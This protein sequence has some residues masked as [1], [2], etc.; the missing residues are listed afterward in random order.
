MVKYSRRLDFK[1]AGEKRGVCVPVLSSSPLGG[2]VTAPLP[3]R[4]CSDRL[5]SGLYFRLRAFGPSP[6]IFEGASPAGSQ[7]WPLY[8]QV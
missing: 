2:G 8:L 5:R 7:A 6:R 3:D 4:S 1:H